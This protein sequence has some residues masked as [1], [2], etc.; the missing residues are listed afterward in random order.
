MRALRDWRRQPWVWAEIAR[1]F[2]GVSMLVFALNSNAMLAGPWKYGPL[3]G[4]L[5]VLWL[6]VIVQTACTRGIKRV[7]FAPVGY[8][9]GLMLA[10]LPSIVAFPALAFA[11]ASTIAFR[12]WWAFFCLGALGTG[13]IGYVLV[14]RSPQLVVAVAVLATP[15]ILSFTQRKSL[16]LPL[17][18]I[19]V[20]SRMTSV[21]RL[22]DIVEE[23]DAAVAQAR[24][25]TFA[26]I[27]D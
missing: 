4:T 6:A 20:R 9:A 22:V 17:N 27:E 13:V 16:R 18:R 23:S 19:K 5:L 21:V 8:C 7:F 2:F 1:G 25:G 24:P 3:A 12:A 15:A 14:G 10:M 11:I 26:R